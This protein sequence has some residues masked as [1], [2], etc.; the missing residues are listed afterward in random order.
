MLNLTDEQ[1]AMFYSSGYY[2]GYRMVFDDI[3]LTID[4]E[5]IHQESVT[6]TQSICS[7]SELVL[8]GC[9]A[10][11]LEFEVSEIMDKDITGIEF[12]CYMDVEDSDGNIVLTVPMGVYRVDSAKCV[13]DKDYKKI[14]AYDVLY[15]VSEDISDF[16]NNIF[17]E[18]EKIKLSEFRS[19][20]L[21]HFGIEFS[22]GEFANDDIYIEK[23]VEMGKGTVTGALLLKYICEINGSFGYIDRYGKFNEIKA[24]KVSGIYPDFNLY[25]SEDLYPEKSNVEF[26]DSESEG[27]QYIETKYEEYETMPITC[28]TIKSSSSDI[29]V[30]SNSD[31]SNPYVIS[32]NFLLFGKSEQ[33][34]KAIGKAIH[35]EIRNIVYRPNTTK[36]YGLPFIDLGDS[37]SLV[38]NR[39][40]VTAFVFSRTLSGIQGLKDEFTAK[41]NK[42]MA[43]ETTSRDEI[44]QLLGKS[45]EIKKSIDGLSVDIK[46]LS[47]NTSS[48]FEQTAE[49]I[50]TEVKRATEKEKKL[51]S[52]IEQTAE[53][54]TS[55]VSKTY[56]TKEDAN[57]SKKKLQASIEQT[58][59]GISSTVSSSQSKWYLENADSYEYGYGLPTIKLWFSS[60]KDYYINVSDGKIYKKTNTSGSWEEIGQAEESVDKLESSIEQFAS[61]IVL[62]VDKNG[63][64]VSVELGVDADSGK[65]YIKLTADNI[66]LTAEEVLDLI[67]DG[68]IDLTGK[69]INISS[70]NFT[71]DS[72]GNVEARSIDIEGGTIHL[73]TT[74]GSNSL[75]KLS[76][77]NVT[78]VSDG[79]E[80][81]IK[82]YS[83]GVP[84]DYE[85]PEAGGVIILPYPQVGDLC[86]DVSGNRLYRFET[87]DGKAHWYERTNEILDEPATVHWSTS[88]LTTG[89]GLYTTNYDS[90]RLEVDDGSGGTT[91]KMF[92]NGS[93]TNMDGDGIHLH[94]T[95]YTTRN[96]T[97]E[98]QELEAN[99]TLETAGYD[100]NL[101]PE[102]VL[103][104]DC[105]SVELGK[106]GQIK[107]RDDALE[108]SKV[109]RPPS[110]ET[111]NVSTTSLQ[112]NGKK[113]VTG[114]VVRN[115][116]TYPLPSTGILKLDA[117]QISS[118][119]PVT[120]V[121]G[122]GEAC[123]DLDFSNIQI[124]PSEG[125]ISVF[126]TTAITGMARITYS[127]W[128]N[129]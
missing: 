78:A 79:K 102:P 38:K 83:E 101:Q 7:D 40:T 63:K 70:D 67:S 108:F 125:A 30:S 105:D 34:L 77:Y 118:E 48:K 17:S 75:I 45:F 71:V 123:P 51:Q 11:S 52:N 107:D 35:N 22:G 94:K 121:N 56:E 39:D 46:N 5:T 109:I 66:N 124:L 14:T 21:E 58:A 129:A 42:I 117:P 1:K 9:I 112:V 99:V 95:M 44:I 64:I 23:T 97:A 26:L 76:N 113:Y 31:E 103:K 85:H 37:Y 27:L 119:Y 60:K 114:S 91:S 6:I 50:T 2:K 3:N 15:D 92:Q 25:P 73:S 20:L 98:Q 96:G 72:D 43:N 88:R 4:N 111:Q 80:L 120:V 62:K 16:Y 49:Q 33:E 116:S 110:V 86:F 29:G 53:A 24:V 18:N 55:S 68:T 57:S 32:S 69:N 115:F 128:A 104:M 81:D 59:E 12:K 10:S 90:V 89:E 106:G 127:Y 100:E 19:K 13:D 41:G 122:D 126:V 61:E 82:Y 65:N 93:T 8:G 84:G 36:L 87:G 28:V 74:N 47:E 54:I